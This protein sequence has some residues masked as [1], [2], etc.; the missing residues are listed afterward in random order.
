MHRLPIKPLSVNAAYR[1]RRFS[2]Q[3]HKDYQ[4]E[5]FYQLPRITVPRD[6]PLMLQIEV[7]LSNR[8]ADLSNTI[9]LFEDIMQKHYGFNDNRVYRLVMDKKIVPKGKEFISFDITSL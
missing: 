8:G 5:V 3:E 9:K 2:T 7:G 1:G 6:G 4:K